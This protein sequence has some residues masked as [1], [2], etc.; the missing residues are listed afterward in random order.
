MPVREEPRPGRTT[1]FSVLSISLP[2]FSLGAL[3]Q[4]EFTV[5][6]STLNV[7]AVHNCGKE[8]ASDK[9]KCSRII[10]IIN[11][12]M[13]QSNALSDCHYQIHYWDVSWVMT[14]WSISQGMMVFFLAL[15]KYLSFCMREISIPCVCLVDR[16][17]RRRRTKQLLWNWLLYIK[18]LCSQKHLSFQL[19]VI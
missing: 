12:I 2:I 11:M 1:S 18:N 3:V 7:S 19:W 15:P 8:V 6:K 13:H 10:I 14:L 9:P 17:E 16:T 4:K 5:M